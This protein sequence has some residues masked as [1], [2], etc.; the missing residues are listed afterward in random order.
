MINRGGEK[1]SPF[2]LEAYIQEIDGVFEVAVFPYNIS[3][4]NENVGVAVVLK[5]RN[6]LSLIEIR[7]YLAQKLN[8]YKLPTCLFVV[9]QIPK[10]DDVK[11]QRSQYLTS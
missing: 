7:T 3:S 4:M 6:D 1:V 11:I 2:E 5:N 8:S 10:N 9:D